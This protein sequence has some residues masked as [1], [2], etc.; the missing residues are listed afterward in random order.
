M[1]RNLA[2]L[3][4]KIAGLLL[5]IYGVLQVPAVLA[6]FFVDRRDP[7]NLVPLVAA[8]VIALLWIML[9][10]GL[11][12][13][14]GRIVDRTMFSE[15]Q[16]GVSSDLRAVEE[17]AFAVLGVYIF[18]SGIA[19]AIRESVYLDLFYRFAAANRQ[20]IAIP[21]SEYAGVA[22]AAT[23]TILGLA[24]FFLSRGVVAVRRRILSLRPMARGR[25]E[26]SSAG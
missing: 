15:P 10:L 11:L 18:V 22:S 24:L 1:E 6:A 19:E 4:T 25:D 5:L 2:R 13:G 21:E 20:A 3:L 9:G 26:A 7:Q 14:T 23:R 12:Y 17:I 8:V 16:A